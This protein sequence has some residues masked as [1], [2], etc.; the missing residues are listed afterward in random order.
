MML[1]GAI[2]NLVDRVRLGRVTDFIDF[3]FWPSFNVADSSITV[4]I[5][6]LLLG[7]ALFAERPPPKT[8]HEE[9]GADRG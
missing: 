5:V 8:E 3:P 2:G 6:V 9:A 4:G 7:Y 1:G